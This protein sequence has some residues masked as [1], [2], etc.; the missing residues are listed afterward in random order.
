[1]LFV[2]DVVLGQRAGV[3]TGVIVFVAT[4]I[5]WTGVPLAVRRTTPDDRGSDDERE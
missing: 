1:M 5:L 4:A 3:V 2:F